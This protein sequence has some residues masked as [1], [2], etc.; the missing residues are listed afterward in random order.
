LSRRDAPNRAADPVAG[1]SR[2]LA[3]DR[4]ALLQA[5]PNPML[6]VAGDGRVVFANAA[7]EQFFGVG[8]AALVRSRLDALVPFGSPIVGLVR[9]ARC[10]EVSFSE[11]DIDLGP[12][13][14]GPRLVHA[15]VVP[16]HEMPGAVLILLQ[17]RS[18]A[19]KMDRHLT[20]RSAARSINGM[21]AVLA[22]E[23]KNPLSGIRGAAQLV[24]AAVGPGDRAL[25]RLICDETDRI[26][27][28]VDRMEAFGERQ[29]L[30][31][32][33]V[34]IHEVLD[35][36]ARL[37]RSGFARGIVLREEYDPSLPPVPGDRDAL[38]QVL[39]N[40]VKNAAEAAPAE[41]GEIVLSTAYRPGVR[42]AVPGSRE[43]LQLPLEVCVR[44]NGA[45]VPDDLKPYLFD[46]FV[47]TKPKGAGLGLPL[48]AKIVGDH[49][50]IIECDSEPRRTVFRVLLPIQA[51][52][53]SGR[54]ETGARR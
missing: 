19:D 7:A 45:G 20:H 16:V 9:K 47:T 28:L 25:T 27:K 35:H 41:G 24:E 52:A 8:A 31:R 18:I 4:E 39:L 37:A 36:V 1:V 54:G 46:P 51:D 30:E 10:T 15:Q 50:G 48:V 14:Q 43:R 22:H 32:G 21:A 38:V 3:V 42:V 49:G 40:L 17:E 53:P 23:I 26:C 12:P 33:P 34:N 11:H 29:T 5:L 6:V 44:D 2:D 13:G